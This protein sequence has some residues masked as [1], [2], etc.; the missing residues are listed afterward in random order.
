MLLLV[1]KDFLVTRPLGMG[2]EMVCPL[3]DGLNARWDF[4]SFYLYFLFYFPPFFSN[5]LM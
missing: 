2:T 3:R 4:V 5:R 1:V